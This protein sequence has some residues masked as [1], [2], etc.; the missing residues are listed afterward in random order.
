MLN[1][2]TKLKYA[3]VNVKSIC[4]CLVTEMKLRSKETTTE[5]RVSFV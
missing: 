3:T 5:L 4:I 1:E 2:I